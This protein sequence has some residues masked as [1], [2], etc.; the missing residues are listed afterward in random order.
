MLGQAISQSPLNVGLYDTDMR[1]LHINAALCHALGM[2]TEA[3]AL[4]HRLSELYP[5]SGFEAFEAF[6]RQ[7]MIIGETA[8]WQAS[9]RATAGTRARAWQVTVS[10]VRDAS[11]RVSGALAVGQDV[12]GHRLARER[13]AL[14]NE[15]SARIGATLDMGTTAG[16]LAEVAVPR[17]ADVVV[18]DLL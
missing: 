18:I 16:E 4:G 17:L 14:V 8:V 11:G 12:T 13:L 3:A 2:K 15:A 5:E 1:H 10:P 9:G 6:A 7:V